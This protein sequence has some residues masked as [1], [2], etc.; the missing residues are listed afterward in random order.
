MAKYVLYLSVG[1]LPRAKAEAFIKD[2]Q[3]KIQE[4]FSPDKIL[5]MPLFGDYQ[6]T[7]VEKLD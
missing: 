3:D 4:F 7:R 2:H 5:V 6:D 1:N